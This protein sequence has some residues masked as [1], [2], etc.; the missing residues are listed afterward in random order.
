[1][2]PLKL[3]SPSR[4]S[5]ALP[6]DFGFTTIEVGLERSDGGTVRLFL[7]NSVAAA[8]SAKNRSA[9]KLMVIHHAGVLYNIYVPST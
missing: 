6:P 4:L 1:M 5:S 3:T 9:Y 7:L 8:L 2:S